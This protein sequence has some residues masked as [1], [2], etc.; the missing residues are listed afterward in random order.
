MTFDNEQQKAFLLE[1]MKQIQVPGNLL[2]IAYETKK[3][4]EAAK[5]EQS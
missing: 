2:D 4:I 1:V 5:V 3:A